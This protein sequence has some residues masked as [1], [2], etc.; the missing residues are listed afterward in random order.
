MM[1]SSPLMKRYMIIAASLILAAVAIACI[2]LRLP[3]FGRNPQGARLDRVERSPQYRDGQF[4][5]Q[6]ATVMMTGGSMWTSAFNMLTGRTKS[7]RNVPAPGEVPVVK[8]DLKHLALDK[9]QYVWFGHSS[10]LLVL[11]GKTLLVDPV[12][13]QF[14]PISSFAKPFPGTDI[15][16]PED[17]PDRIDYLLISHDHYDHLDYNTVKAL[18]ER[19]GKVI[20]PLGVGE[21]FERWGYDAE[22]IV[23]L[24]WNDI[25]RDELVFHCLPSR[26]FSG[27]SLSRNTTQH[28]SWVIESPD[29]KIFY[30]GDGGFGEHFESIGKQFPDIDLAIMENGQYDKQWCHMHTMPSELGKELCLLKP[31][32][33]ITV[34]HSKVALANHAWDEPRQNERNAADESHIPLIVC[35]I[36][37]PVGL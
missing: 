22:R 23:E 30:S 35:K 16:H 12:L 29:R 3:A 11:S 27:R 1:I 8:S 21:N 5:N 32:R 18:R 7:K 17:M 9:D 33:F 14:S 28:G 34:H 31:Q 26:H 19:V 10:F 25:S 2:V 24:D 6:E 37:E 36:G 15:Y 13:C 20:C 4:Q